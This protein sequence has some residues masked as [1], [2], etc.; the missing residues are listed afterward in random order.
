[1]L[2]CWHSR[3]IFVSGIFFIYCCVRS[4]SHSNTHP[5]QDIAGVQTPLL[6]NAPYSSSISNYN[7]FNLDPEAAS[8]TN[9]HLSNNSSNDSNIFHVQFGPFS[10]T[11]EDESVD[12]SGSNWSRTVDEDGRLYYIVSSSNGVL[13][14]IRPLGYSDPQES[15]IDSMQERISGYCFR[16]SECISPLTERL[17]FPIRLIFTLSSF[18]IEYMNSKI[19]LALEWWTQTTMALPL[20]GFILAATF[21]TWIFT[22]LD[23]ILDFDPTD[24]DRSTTVTIDL[25][26]IAL[27]PILLHLNRILIRVLM[28]LR[29]TPPID[30]VSPQTGHSANALS[31]IWSLVFRF[32]HICTTP[33]G[34]ESCPI[35]LEEFSL[36][37]PNSRLEC[38][39]HL[40]L[41][42]LCAYLYYHSAAICPLC[43]QPIIRE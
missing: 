3:R 32:H 9:S 25:F 39:H 43:R 21:L 10:R 20:P 12:R 31:K 38:G 33:V 29:G 42:C 8:L 11:N 4:N 26:I 28:T 27:A 2:R 1:M 30:Q 36:L 22:I 34:Q 41:L 5:I 6:A 24:P 35:C 15:T 13:V 17:F 37:I 40:H 7:M 19:R 14:E 16:I 23:L 18:G